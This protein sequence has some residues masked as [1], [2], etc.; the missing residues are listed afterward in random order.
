MSASQQV[1]VSDASSVGEA[2]R[3]AQGFA[4]AL[5]FG[6]HERAQI[7]IVVTETA[8]N[9]VKHARGGS[10]LMRA[11]SGAS[12]EGAG[13]RAVGDGLEILAIDD[14]PGIAEGARRDGHSTAGTLG[15]GLGAIERLAGR[16][17]M[18]TRKD[19]GVVLLAQAW[20]SA[21][22]VETAG[23]GF[24]VGAISVPVAGEVECGDDWSVDVRGPR[25]RV[26]VV[27]GLGHGPL[28]ARAAREAVASF[29][30]HHGDRPSESIQRLHA[31]LRSTR[32]AAALVVHLDAAIGIATWCGVGNVSASIL[33]AGVRRQLVSHNGTLGHGTF[34]TQEFQAPWPDGA[35]LVAATDGVSARWNLDAYP[36]LESRHPALVAGIL[37]RDFT[38]GRDDATIVAVG[39]RRR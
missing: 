34:R 19:G 20:P 33:A 4:E 32:G 27:D 16:S 11:L 7:G 23:R 5:G 35:L 3:R 26:L 8:S 30:A 36:G 37:Y 14:G 24:E 9:I 1:A 13:G 15:I 28:A 12:L 29:D 6:E 17:E 21:P 38:R 18:Y 2:R 10:I 25:A 31:V 39:D 22:P